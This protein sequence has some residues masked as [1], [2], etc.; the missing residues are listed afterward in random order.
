MF[1]GDPVR[2]PLALALHPAGR[3]SRLAW[4]TVS[5]AALVTTAACGVGGGDDGGGGGSGSNIDEG[6]VCGATFRVTG[7][8]AAGM[9]GRPIDPDTMMP[10][11]GCWPVGTWTFTAALDGNDCPAPPAAL[12]SYSFRVDRKAPPDGGTD[13]IESY[14]NLTS[15]GDMQNHI[16]VT[17]T[18]QG[19][20]GH[21]EFGSADGKQYWNMKPLL[22]KDPATTALAGDAY[23]E[24]YKGNAW[25]WK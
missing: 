18:G 4:T 10:Q 22:L 7:T 1:R 3:M 14:V 15:A 12:A 9:P 25:P 11:T 13:L 8:F 23:Y 17:S 16:K 20:E 19:C 5:F 21:V 2:S 24:L 6:M